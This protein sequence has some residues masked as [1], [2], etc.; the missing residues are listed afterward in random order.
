MPFIQD[1]CIDFLEYEKIEDKRQHSLL[2]FKQHPALGSLLSA[3]LNIFRL[4]LFATK[5][6]ADTV[7][8]VS[9]IGILPSHG[10][11]LCIH[12]YLD[13][14]YFYHAAFGATFDS[15]EHNI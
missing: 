9:A 3:Y 4:H 1:Y 13:D 2:T 5:E 7:K 12:M 14:K 10:I 8:R 15:S 11:L 6:L